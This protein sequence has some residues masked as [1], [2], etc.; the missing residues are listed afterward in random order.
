MSLPPL[1][2][3]IHPWALVFAAWGVAALSTLSA[4]F[5]G[6]VM[7]LPICVLC[8]YQRIAMFPLAL[9][10]PLGLFPFDP[11]VIRYGLMLAVPGLL[12]ALF[13]LLLMAG[14][15]PESIQPCEQGVPCSQTVIQWFGFLTI[16]MLS[17]GAFSLIVGLLI[18]AQLRSRS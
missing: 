5:L 2:N 12:L 6:E 9:I 18:L 4:L 15:I 7:K 11:K 13:H 10:L 8:W 1:L 14:I 3:R 17:I 16:P